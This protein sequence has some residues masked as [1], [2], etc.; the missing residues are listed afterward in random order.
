MGNTVLYLG[1]N[2]PNEPESGLPGAGL[3]R[4]CW[5]TKERHRHV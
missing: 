5:C 2:F 1:Q 3:P 4:G